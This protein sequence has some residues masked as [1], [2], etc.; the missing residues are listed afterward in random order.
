MEPGDTNSSP[1]Q[2]QIEIRDP[3][4]KP[5]RAKK[6]AAPLRRRRR[7]LIYQKFIELSRDSSGHGYHNI[8]RTD[9]SLIRLFWIIFFLA[10]C[11]F[12]FHLIV[13][14]VSNYSDYNV[15]SK[16]R[17]V[18]DFKPN[19]PMVSVCN[20]NPFVTRQ[21][22]DFFVD[23]LQKTVSNLSQ[24]D[25]D[26][27]T[28]KDTNGQNRLEFYDK[29]S[30]LI[31]TLQNMI[32]SSNY[33]NKLRKSFGFNKTQMFIEYSYGSN[34][35][36]DIMPYISWYY[37]SQFGNCFKINSGAM[38]DGRVMPLLKQP[39]PGITNG[40]YVTAF[41]DVYKKSIYNFMNF[42]P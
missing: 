22:R 3:E 14:G 34:Q 20:T 37:D 17:I 19:F 18:N 29:N 36:V 10:S 16:I 33:S 2:N 28:G 27:I 9:K 13:K 42:D 12:C 1:D 5:A 23:L 8:Y 25:L 30:D 40:L 11:S 15:N 31:Y 35:D 32:T 38:E 4:H 41:V 39:Q 26:I 6:T 21:A 24:S 7:H